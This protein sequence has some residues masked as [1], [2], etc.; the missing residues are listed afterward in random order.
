MAIARYRAAPGLMIEQGVFYRALIRTDC[1]DMLFDLYPHIA[2]I[3]VNNFV[4]L[5]TQGFYRLSTFHRVIKDFVIQGG[6]PNG[7]GTGDPGY[8]FRDEPVVGRYVRGTLAMSNIGRNSNGSQFFIVD[9]AEL[10]LPRRFTIFGSMLEGWDTLD[11]IT[12]VPRKISPAHE[13]AQPV[14][15]LVIENIEIQAYYENRPDPE[16]DY[17]GQGEW[18]G[19]PA[20]ADSDDGPL[21]GEVVWEE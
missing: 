10:D 18:E 8:Y 6:C 16:Y 13:M 19:T 7:D 1:G 3:T 14:D 11:R 20:P 4:F 15:P 21:T 2:P 5:A 9:G 12:G 17:D